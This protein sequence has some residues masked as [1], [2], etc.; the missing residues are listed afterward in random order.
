[1]QELEFG[2]QAVNYDKEADNPVIVNKPD[3]LEDRTIL[4]YDEK[5]QTGLLPS[6]SFIHIIAS[7]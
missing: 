7:L 4:E 5:P 3:F 6:S 1:M 2:D